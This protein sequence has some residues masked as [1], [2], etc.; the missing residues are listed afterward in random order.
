MWRHQQVNAR[1]GFG[2]DPLVGEV[3]AIDEAGEMPGN[4]RYLNIDPLVQLWQQHHPQNDLLVSFESTGQWSMQRT[5]ANLTRL[6]IF[7]RKKNV[8][9][10]ATIDTS[11]HDMPY[12]EVSSQTTWSN[13]RFQIDW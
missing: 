8:E 1:I 13:H 4:Q 5:W 7:P 2:R 9:D 11:C 6:Y 3:T 12:F 10:K